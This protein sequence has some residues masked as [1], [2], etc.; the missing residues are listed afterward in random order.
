MKWVVSEPETCQMGGAQG[1]HHGTLV[2]AHETGAGI[3]SWHQLS[4]IH[5]ELQDGAQLYFDASSGCLKGIC[6]PKQE[7][8]TLHEHCLPWVSDRKGPYLE[9]GP[10]PFY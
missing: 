5:S 9:E 4:S 3:H 7:D 8:V 2:K 6:D 1:R 10:G